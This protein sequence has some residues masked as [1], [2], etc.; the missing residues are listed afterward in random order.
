LKSKQ[1][2]A[3][4]PQMIIKNSNKNPDPVSLLLLWMATCL[5]FSL[6]YILTAQ[7]GVSW[8]DSGEFQWRVLIGD[9]IGN[10]GL[11]RAHPLYIALGKLFVLLP[12]GNF[13][14][15]LNYASGIGMAIALANMAVIATWFTGQRRV[16]FAAA[17]IVS[18][19]HAVWWLSTIAEVYTWHVALF[20]GELL[21]LINVI[22]KPRWHTTA[23]L[24]FLNGLNVCIHNLALLPLPVYV[25]AVIL[26]QIKKN[27]SPMTIFICGAAYGIGASFFIS[28]IIN[29]AVHT[30][31]VAAALQS[32]LFGSYAPAVLN[33]RMSGDYLK[34]NAALMSLSFFNAIVPFAILGWWHMKRQIG[35]FLAGIF[36]VITLIEFVFVIR[37]PV[38]DQ[39]TFILPSLIMLSIAGAVGISV[40][41]DISKNWCNTVIALCLLSIP[42]PPIAYANAPA[43]IRKM[44]MEIERSRELP[45]RDELRYWIVPWKHNE[46]SAELFAKAALKEAAPAGTIAC[47]STSYYPLKLV[48]LQENLSPGVTIRYAGSI[49]H[50]YKQDG[51]RMLQS[52]Q[53]QP[54]FLISP[55]L[56]F[57]PADGLKKITIQR[58]NGQV[59][60]KVEQRRNDQ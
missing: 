4:R 27:L 58:G 56:D 32:A 14:A 17:A 44:G 41:S 51:Q 7:Q 45:F 12:G 31:N 30:G 59:L 2:Y 57:L 28:L 29:Q 20:T 11:A 37:Y 26:L 52:L 19:M 46:R 3:L 23:L 36:A 40:L 21:I 34:I 42:V 22:N 60:Y 49:K 39:F 54:L 1:G 33:T 35:S 6:F 53:V 50:F 48:Q 43:L 47:D 24:F 15:K 38:P 8:Q 55:V 13:T 16:G 18:V 5:F 25:F 10:L 9:Y